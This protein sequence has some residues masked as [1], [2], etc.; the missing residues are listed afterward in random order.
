[1]LR[2]DPVK[3]I[4]IFLGVIAV[5]IGFGGGLIL[6]RKRRAGLSAA[7][8]KA[9]LA[10]LRCWLRS[11]A[12]PARDSLASLNEFQPPPQSPHQSPLQQRPS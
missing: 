4:A 1:M 11:D 3:I 7:Q 6:L 12:V 10:Q 2:A 5:V 8:R 9:V